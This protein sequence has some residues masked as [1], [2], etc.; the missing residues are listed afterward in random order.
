MDNRRF[1][2]AIL[3]S[4]G[5]LLAWGWLFPP[6]EEPAP[7]EGPVVEAPAEA[8]LRAEPPELEAEPQPGGAEDVGDRGQA[9]VGPAV[10][11]S[12][13]P[14]AEIFQ[15]F[16][17]SYERPNQSVEPYSRSSGS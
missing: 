16:R 12:V 13:E 7:A 5:V 1:L 14:V 8:P 11:Q 3:L 4:I 9:E 17:R 15:G 2:L 10:G 6:P